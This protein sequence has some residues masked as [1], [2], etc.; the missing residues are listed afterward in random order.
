MLPFAPAGPSRPCRPRRTLGARHALRPG[1]TLQTD[2]ALRAARA[3][4]ARRRR[5][6]ANPPRSRRPAVRVQP[7]RAPGRPTERAQARPAGTS[8]PPPTHR[9][10]RTPRGPQFDTQSPIS[11]VTVTRVTRQSGVRKSTLKLNFFSRVRARPEL[12]ALD[13]YQPVGDGRLADDDK[14]ASG[15]R[16]RAQGKV[17]CAGHRPGSSRAAT[18][19]R[20]RR[21][22]YRRQEAK[23]ERKRYPARQ[24]QRHKMTPS[25]SDFPS[26]RPDF[27]SRQRSRYS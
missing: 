6:A 3:V 24:C 2:V 23:N 27:L 10:A 4:L 18:L 16:H 19:V 12:G 25:R 14:P 9:A 7:Q 26:P 17:R 8:P 1:G 20:G 21:R 22:G 11:P 5:K 15:E 13:L